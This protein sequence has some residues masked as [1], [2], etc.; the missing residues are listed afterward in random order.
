MSVKVRS[1][2][3]IVIVSLITLLISACTPQKSPSS[4]IFTEAAR[5]GESKTAAYKS[6]TPTAVPTKT[7]TPTITPLPT[8][9]PTPEPLDATVVNDTFLFSGPGRVY[10]WIHPLKTGAR[11]I[12]LARSEDASWFEVSV[13]NTDW[14]GWVISGQI[15]IDFLPELLPVSMNIPPTPTPG[16]V[17][18]PTTP[19]KLEVEVVITNKLPVPVTVLFSGPMFSST[20]VNSGQTK[21]VKLAVG[22]YTYTARAAGFIEL[23]EKM[24]FKAGKYTLVYSVK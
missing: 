14:V 19:L 12:V 1:G 2:F 4:S 10:P 18:T 7:S 22:I 6:R 11:L 20:V 3:F 9:T 5:I 23:A 21:T 8:Q 16:V 13:E 24:E 17:A 15:S